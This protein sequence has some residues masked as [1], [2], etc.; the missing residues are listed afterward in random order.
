MAN[1]IERTYRP[2]PG[3]WTERLQVR[4]F[5][6]SD[7]MHRFLN[8][9]ANALTWRESTKGLAAGTYAYAGGKWHNV[10]KLDALTLAHV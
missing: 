4:T 5:R 7:T 1:A 10:K 6:D 8:T 3:R 9:G 2:F